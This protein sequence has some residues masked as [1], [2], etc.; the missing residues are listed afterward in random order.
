TLRRLKVQKRVRRGGPHPRGNPLPYPA[1][2]QRR[3]EPCRLRRRATDAEGDCRP[4]T[5]DARSWAHATRRTP[6]R[7]VSVSR[8][9]RRAPT[10][11]APYTRLARLADK[12]KQPPA[13]SRNPKVSPIARCAPAPKSRRPRR[14][15]LEAPSG[16]TP[17]WA[18]RQ[19]RAPF[20]STL[21]CCPRHWPCTL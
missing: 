16:T 7:P 4:R 14:P 3:G 15:R 9:R 1:E 21:A 12:S 8:P 13:S 18:L 5:R 17:A 2:R 19:P 10:P 6:C 20:R 11:R